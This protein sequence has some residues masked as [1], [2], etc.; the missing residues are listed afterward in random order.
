MA[1]AGAATEACGGPNLLSIYYANKKPVSPGDAV[2]PAAIAPFTYQ[3]CYSDN[4][5]K[6]RALGYN[7]PDNTNLTVE[8]CVQLCSSKG[9]SI[10][11]MEYS[12]ECYC[13]NF[14][15]YAPSLLADTKCNM[16]CAG[17]SAEK[18]GGGNIVSLFREKQ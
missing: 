11:G 7:Q 3:G 2:D 16:N 15:R 10:A 1:C 4:S 17:N 6:G 5:P 12:T 14:I 13:D 8:S 18:C 9:Y